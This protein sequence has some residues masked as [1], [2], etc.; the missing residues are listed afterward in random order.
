MPIDAESL[1]QIAEWRRI[2]VAVSDGWKARALAAEAE[3]D[4]L[5]EG[6]K[7]NIEHQRALTAEA[8]AHQLRTESFVLMQRL[9]KVEAALEECRQDWTR[10]ILRA[11]K[12]ESALREIVGVH[13]RWE[14]GELDDSTAIYAIDA[15][16]QA[17]TALEGK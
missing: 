10:T 17:R 13:R 5:V 15:L 4:M 16:V 11:D 9:V 3:R 2:G 1:A 12:A 14:L 8:D 6:I 7:N